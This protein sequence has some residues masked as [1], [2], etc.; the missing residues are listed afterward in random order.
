MVSGSAGSSGYSQDHQRPCLRISTDFTDRQLATLRT[1]TLGH[2]IRAHLLEWTA[3]VPTFAEWWEDLPPGQWLRAPT[4]VFQHLDHV[5]NLH[6]C[7]SHTLTP[8][9]PSG[10]RDT[11]GHSINCRAVSQS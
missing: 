6:D 11:L 4:V 7:A 8:G 1:I 5:A 10:V 2:N 9:S 3:H